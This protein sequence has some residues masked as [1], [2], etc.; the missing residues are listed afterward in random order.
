MKDKQ[1]ETRIAGIVLVAIG[2]FVLTMQLVNFDAHELFGFLI[3]P[4]IGAILVLAGIFSH[5]A[6]AIIPGGIL[7]GIGWGA[8]AVHYLELSYADSS[9]GAAF[10]FVFALGWVSITVATALFTAKTHWWPLIPA[11][12][13]TLAGLIAIDPVAVEP[14]LDLLEKVWPLALI[15]AGV[16]VLFRAGK[17]IEGSK[18]AKVLDS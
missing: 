6:G 10:L 5:N 16:V 9:T 1:K 17:H 18:E 13:V 8:L 15:V 11:A 7:S 2:L 14:Y 3:L 12:A 4:G